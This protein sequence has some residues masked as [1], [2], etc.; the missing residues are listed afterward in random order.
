MRLIS[1]IATLTALWVMPAGSGMDDGAHS[2]RAPNRIT[3]NSASPQ[4]ARRIEWGLDR[5]RIA[6]LALPPLSISVHDNDGPCEGNSGLYRTN[7]PGEVHLCSA[8]RADS[9]TAKLI[10]LHE[11]A[12]AWAE[13]QLTNDQ[14][15]AFLQLRALD[16][17]VDQ[18]VPTHRWGAEHAA[19]VVSWGLMD[20]A[21]PIVRIYN[22]EPAELTVAFES[23]TGQAPIWEAGGAGRTADHQAPRSGSAEPSIVSQAPRRTQFR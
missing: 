10:T 13:T 16:T 19:E 7:E 6:G 3:I 23:L 9:T 12:H 8:S 2:E 4:W 20:E 11:L 15:A 17:W 22:A 21:V 5:F 14:Q 1:T 18:R